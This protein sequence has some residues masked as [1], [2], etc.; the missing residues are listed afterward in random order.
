LDKDHHYDAL[1]ALRVRISTPDEQDF[2]RANIRHI[3]AEHGSPLAADLVRALSM[4]D[5]EAADRVAKV[6]CE[7]A[8]FVVTSTK[9]PARVEWTLGE[10]SGSTKMPKG[11]RVQA[12]VS[13][14]IAARSAAARNNAQSPK[15]TDIK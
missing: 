14:A 4:Q 7:D 2:L 12:I 3:E 10:I 9:T 8:D 5:A 6:L 13:A 1:A 11:T 15:P